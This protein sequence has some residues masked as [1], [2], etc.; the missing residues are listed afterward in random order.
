MTDDPLAHPLDLQLRPDPGRTVLRPFDLATAADHEADHHGRLNRIVQQVREMAPE[1]L[2]RAMGF[3]TARL[4][5][6]HRD[7]QDVL[8][9]NAD[10]LAEIVP[11][12]RDLDPERHFLFGGYVTQEYAFES[13]ALF[14]PCVMLMHTQDGVPEGSVRLLCSLRGIG[15][16]HVSSVTFRTLVWDGGDGLSMEEASQYAVAPDIEDRPDCAARM[17]F[18]SENPSE[19][20]LFPVLASQ[21]RGLEDLRMVRLEEPNGEL[22]TLGTYTAVGREGSQLHIMEKHAEAAFDLWPVEGELSKSKGGAI[23]PRQIDGRYLM[24]SRQDGES[25]WLAESHDLVTWTVL[26]QLMTGRYPWEFAQ[27]GNCGSPIEIDEG[28]LLLTHGVGTIRNYCIGACLLD[29]ADPSKMLK[30]MPVPLMRPEEMGRDG[31]VPNVVY[32][33]GGYVKGRTLLLPFGVADYFTRFATVDLD[34]LL[35]AMVDAD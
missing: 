6:R 5:G 29:K 32:S 25:L 4:D 22:R 3:T 17:K 20:I 10:A 7:T 12:V 14:N 9:R 1:R 8:R 19:D 2:D 23:F 11:G 26:G 21:A 30:R 34:R 28:W 15:E 31:Y 33:C 24:V 16:G 18:G 35:A 27:I 13:A